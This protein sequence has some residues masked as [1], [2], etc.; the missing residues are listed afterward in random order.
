MYLIA[1][2]SVIDANSLKQYKAKLSKM[3]K[4]SRTVHA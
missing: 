1:N 2:L 3:N 4:I